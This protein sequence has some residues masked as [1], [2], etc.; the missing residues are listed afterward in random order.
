MQLSITLH[1]N[2]FKSTNPNYLMQSID[3]PFAIVTLFKPS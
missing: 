1:L 2:I 3:N